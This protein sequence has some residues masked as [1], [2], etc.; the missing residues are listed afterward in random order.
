[1]ASL[2]LRTFLLAVAT[3]VGSVVVAILFFGLS[4]THALVQGLVITGGCWALLYRAARGS[5]SEPPDAV[6]ETD[7]LEGLSRIEFD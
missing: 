7:I 4:L 6:T 3:G 2:G 1:M 5:P